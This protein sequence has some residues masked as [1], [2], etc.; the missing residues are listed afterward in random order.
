MKHTPKYHSLYIHTPPLTLSDTL[1]ILSGSYLILSYQVYILWYKPDLSLQVVLSFGIVC[2]IPS[3]TPRGITDS[4][5]ILDLYYTRFSGPYRAETVFQVGQ[6]VETPN[7]FLY[8]F[9]H[10]LPSIRSAFVLL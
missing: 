7:A 10:S 5:P 8:T 3:D 9:I 1:P 6:P 2:R 4:K